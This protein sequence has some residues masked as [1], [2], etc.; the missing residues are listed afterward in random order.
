[1]I[2]TRT[3]TIIL[4][5]MMMKMYVCF[6]HQFIRRL[7]DIWRSQF[8]TLNIPNIHFSFSYV[9]TK[10]FKRISL[11]VVKSMSRF[12]QRGIPMLSVNV[13]CTQKENCLDLVPYCLHRDISWSLQ[14]LFLVN[15]QETTMVD[16]QFCCHGCEFSGYILLLVELWIFWIY[17]D[18]CSS[19]SS[20]IFF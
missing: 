7:V 11:F 9:I 20:C 14:F 16:F 6:S 18:I 12:L 1:M 19:N 4:M 13:P 5:M 8:A 10:V 15:G 3:S 2:L 17:L